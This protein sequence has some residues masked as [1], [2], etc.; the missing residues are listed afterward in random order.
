MRMKV[1][2]VL[3]SLF[4]V[5][6][7]SSDGEEAATT[8]N[9]GNQTQAAAPPPPP[10]PAPSGPADGSIEQFMQVAGDRVFFA[11]DRSDLS[12]QAQS[13][14]DAQAQWLNAFPSVTIT[15]EG[16]ADERGTDDYNLA[17]SARRAAAVRDYLIASGVSASRI[18]TLAFGESR[19]VATGSN[20][21]AWAQ[22]RRAVTVLT[23]GT[24]S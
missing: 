5:A 2:A 4:L 23:G 7:C 6:A 3:A 1:L 15:V 22:N 11:L 8:Q 24:T 9:T 21:A 16:H 17:L 18:E 10:P 13:T 14:L 12:P 19:P 20:E